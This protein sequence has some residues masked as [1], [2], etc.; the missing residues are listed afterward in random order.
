MLQAQRGDRA[1]FEVLYREFARVVHGIVLAH[2]GSRDAEDVTQDVFVSAYERLAELREPAAF[3]S[4]LCTAARHAAIDHRRRRQ[5]RPAAA[6]LYDI[7][8]GGNSPAQ[9]LAAADAAARILGKIQQLGEAYRETL[10][11]RLVEGLTG[12]EIAARTGMTHGSVRVNLTRG[13]AMLRPL[14][15]EA[16][17]A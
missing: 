9:A 1:A 14:L 8:A 15:Q 2:C 6:E 17:L 3:P 16:G 13:M 7:A 4:W 11:L 10:V 5:R 12:P